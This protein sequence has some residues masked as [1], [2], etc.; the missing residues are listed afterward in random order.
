MLYVVE[1]KLF[2]LHA[3]SLLRLGHGSNRVSIPR[4]YLA[5]AIDNLLNRSIAQCVHLENQRFTVC[6][7]RKTVGGYVYSGSLQ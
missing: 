6:D 1:A 2:L 5:Q 4:R 3:D 7:R